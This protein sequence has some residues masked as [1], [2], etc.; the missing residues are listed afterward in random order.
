MSG[1]RR[2]RGL[3]LAVGLLTC[4]NA[5]AD[6]YA[7]RDAYAKKD[8]PRAF[9]LYRELAEMGYLGGQEF[10]ADMYVGGDGV[11]RDNALGYAWAK[12]AKEN[13][14]GAEMQNI[15]DQ[16]EP[17]LTA[18]ARA[19]VGEIHAQYG[20]EAIEKRWI[21]DPQREETPPTATLCKLRV[22]VNPQE[23]FPEAARNAGYSGKVF[24]QF[25]VAPD[26]H[27]R[28]PRVWFS[29]PKDL[30]DNAARAVVMKS[31][32]TP[33][34]ENGVADSCSMRILIKFELTGSGDGDDRIRRDFASLE[35]QATAGDPFFQTA[36]A[37][38]IATRP[39]LNSRHESYISPLL[40]AAQAGIPFA[41]YM[42]GVHTLDGAI[43]RRDVA[44]GLLWLNEAAEGGNAEAQVTLANHLM[45]SG[46][47]AKVAVA[48][49]E[50]S[51]A[52]GNIEGI[53]RLSAVLAA[54]PDAALRDPQ[55][56]LTL[57]SEKLA[58]A[59]AV[60]APS[61]IRAAAHAMLGD[62]AAAEKD[63]KRAVSKVRILGWDRSPQEARLA[64]YQAKKSW[65]G[66]LIEF[67]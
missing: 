20:K 65:T 32:Y 22:P 11:K 24:V 2:F 50:K 52:A 44:K 26:G 38:V 18:K 14:A 7:A 53:Y 42:I 62:F 36:Y 57:V 54:S 31:I 15:I 21:P 13:G 33:R 56:A 5:R 30:F 16:L 41:Q 59:D 6:L 45:K 43:V 35:S 64:A 47:D 63:Q 66:D 29:T 28:N 46:G 1:I 23:F 55:K 48:W 9:E 40:K 12:V 37:L 49:L 3:W 27:A 67:D 17:H 4:V 34:K 10:V 25:T 61:D 60:P 19:V 39:E 8:Y 51:A 58:I